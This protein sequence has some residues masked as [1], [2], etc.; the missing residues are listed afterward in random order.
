MWAPR[1]FF[2]QGSL[3]TR[4]DSRALVAV[5]LTPWHR[6][7]YPKYY[8]P[9][10]P[11]YCQPQIPAAYH[12]LALSLWYPVSA[13]IYER[14][15]ES[16]ISWAIWAYKLVCLL[17]V[18]LKK[19][20][21][22]RLPTCDFAW[23]WDICYSAKLYHPVHSFGAWPPY[24]GP[25]SEALVHGVGSVGKRS[26]TLGARKIMLPQFLILSEDQDLLCKK[27]KDDIRSW[28]RKVWS[29]C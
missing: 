18:I 1:Y 3:S 28:A 27:P 19:D 5:L 25:V 26:S 8:Q 15:C 10:T 24:R 17:G 11:Y 22:T 12:S 4:L 9:H 20:W 14:R 29:Q 16:S 7:C 6:P 2:L 23:F 21:E 13:V